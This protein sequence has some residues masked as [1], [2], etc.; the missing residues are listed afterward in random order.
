MT[1]PPHETPI[2]NHGLVGNMRSAA[3]VSIDGDIDFFGYPE[4]DSP[5]VFAALLD[6]ENGGSF[7]LRPEATGFTVDRSPFRT[8]TSF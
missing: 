7:S 2:Q 6:R 8:P 4:F 1:E 5:T 3:L